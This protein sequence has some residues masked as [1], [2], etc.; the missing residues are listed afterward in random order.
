VLLAAPKL[1]VSPAFELPV[2]AEYVVFAFAPVSKNAQPFGTVLD[3]PLL[4]SVSKFSVYAESRAV[5][6]MLPAAN[7]AGRPAG[8][9]VATSNR[10]RTRAPIRRTAWAGMGRSSATA[11]R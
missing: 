7:V 10:G 8:S 3:V 4:A 1:Y 6:L 9:P 11:R 2:P 5:R